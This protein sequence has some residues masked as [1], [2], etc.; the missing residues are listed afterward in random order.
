MGKKPRSPFTS[1]ESSG[2]S[3][4]LIRYRQAKRIAPRATRV[5]IEKTSVFARP[6]MNLEADLRQNRLHRAVRILAPLGDPPHPVFN[7][8]LADFFSHPGH[9]RVA[10][11]R[12]Q[13][14]SRHFHQ[15]LLVIRRGREVGPTHGDSIEEIGDAVAAQ[16]GNFQDRHVLEGRGA[17]EFEKQFLR[18]GQVGFV[19]DQEIGNLKHPRL[20]PLHFVAALGGDYRQDGLRDATD[21]DL[22]LADADSL[23]QYVFFAQRIEKLHRLDNRA[24]NA[25]QASPCRQA[26]DKHAVVKKMIAHADAVAQKRAAAKRTGRIDGQNSNFL[27]S[28]AELFG[29]AANERALSRSG[30]AG[31]ANDACAPG[32]KKETLEDFS[33][34]RVLIV[35]QGQ[36]SAGRSVIA[37][38]D[39]GG[40]VA[41]IEP[42]RLSFLKPRLGHRFAVTALWR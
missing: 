11:Q 41:D 7:V 14:L 35:D 29:Y 17:A 27:F 30:G 20:D 3:I 18:A 26:S 37:A 23:D 4:S 9:Q 24:G 34:Q 13:L 39:R 16:R 8:I 2:V 6:A 15:S 32:A 12:Q 28:P 5:P 36:H 19:D 42:S 31:D 22:V 21:I 38:Q 40:K 10:K 25:A 1:K 33:G